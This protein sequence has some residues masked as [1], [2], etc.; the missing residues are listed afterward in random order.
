MKE[1][2]W[3]V[4]SDKNLDEFLVKIE[5][6]SGKMVFM[7]MSVPDYELMAYN[8]QEIKRYVK[9]TKEVI[10]YYRTVMSDDEEKEKVTG[11]K[12]DGRGNKN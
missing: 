8:L 2:K 12:D 5:K 4:V 1:P 9:E 6:E 3:Y 10:V 7:A 11:E